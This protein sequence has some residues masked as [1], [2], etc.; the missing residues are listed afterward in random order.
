MI[1]LTISVFLALI[2]SLYVYR[3]RQINLYLKLVRPDLKSNINYIDSS[4]RQFSYYFVNYNDLTFKSITGATCS[5]ASNPFESKTLCTYRMKI[6][7][8]RI[9]LYLLD[10]IDSYWGAGSKNSDRQRQVI[11]YDSVEKCS[12][13]VINL[14]E[15]ESQVESEKIKT[16]EKLMA[17]GFD[18]ENALE[19]FI[20]ERYK[21]FINEAP[22]VSNS[23]KQASQRK[24]HKRIHE[25]ANIDYFWAIE[26]RYN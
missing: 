6:N 12:K 17:E 20:F 14:R 3:R 16:Y 22:E 11:R 2:S 15:L 24:L 9:R 25:I 5:S 13:V 4:T 19:T 23:I 8:G 10:V 1:Y 21:K 18:C 26:E 7:N